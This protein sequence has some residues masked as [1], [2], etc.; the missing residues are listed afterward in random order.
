M[1]DRNKFMYSD[2]DKPGWGVENMPYPRGLAYISLRWDRCLGCGLCEIACSMA[3]YGVINRELS[4]IRIYRYPS[5]L[6]PNPSKMFA[7]SARRR[8]GS[9]RRPAPSTRP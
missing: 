5:C 7:S 8:N 9:A 4:R 6:C 3:H 2:P 1:A